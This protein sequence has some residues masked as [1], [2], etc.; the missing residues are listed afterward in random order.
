M[1]NSPVMWELHDNQTARFSVAYLAGNLNGAWTFFTA[2]GL[3]LA[4]SRLVTAL[5]AAAALVVAGLLLAKRRQWLLMAPLPASLVLFG[6]GTVAITALMMFY[7]WASFSDPM[8]AR[9]ALPFYLLLILCIVVAAAWAD[10]RAPV[11]LVVLAAAAAFTLTVSAPKQGYHFYSHMGND[12]LAWEQRV[13][14]AR[15]PGP[16]LILSNK[17]TLPWMI[18]RTPAILIER[19]RAV[20]DRLAE[21]LRLPDFT[22]ILVTQSMRPTS[23]EGQYQLVPEEALPPWIH[24]ELLAERRF[25]TKLARISRVVSIDLPADF[26]PSSPP[27]AGGESD[28]ADHPAL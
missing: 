15:R 18:T 26:K 19:A 28:A 2:D 27:P 14:D 20:A 8:A 12:E 3:S 25:G 11:S 4:N 23:A 9:F 17:S 10:R 5:G 21:H 22:E 6:G 16:R 1:S 13:I 24:L 7:Y